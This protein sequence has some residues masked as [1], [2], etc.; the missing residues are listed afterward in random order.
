VH[1]L[2]IFLINGC[3]SGACKWRAYFPAFINSFYCKKQEKIALNLQAY[4]PKRV[5]HDR[6]QIERKMYIKRCVLGVSLTHKTELKRMLAGYPVKTFMKGGRHQPVK[7]SNK[8][9]KYLTSSG[10]GVRPLY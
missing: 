8:S 3:G 10:L 1:F 7:L 4:S 6:S 5:K 2:S 9:R